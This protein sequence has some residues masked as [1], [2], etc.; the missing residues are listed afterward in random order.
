MKRIRKKHMAPVLFIVSSFA[1][2]ILIGTLLLWCP[3]STTSGNH[4]NFIDAFFTSTSAVC[5]TGLSPVKDLSLTLTVFGKIVLAFLIQ[6]GGLGMV[7]IGVFILTIVGAKIGIGNRYLVK[8]ALNQNTANG[9]VKLVK[10]IVLITFIIE[11]VGFLLN[12]IVFAQDF[13]LGTAIGIS[14]FHAISSFNNAGFDIIGSSSLVPYTNNVLLNLSTAGMI[15]L[16]GLG[17]IV[18]REII[19]KRSLRK[20]SIHSKIVLKVTLSLI[21]IGTLLIKLLEGDN[22]TWLQAFFQ[23]VTARTAGFATVD[24]SLLSNATTVLFFFLMF[25]GAAPCSTG[26]GIKVSAFYTIYKSIT[27]FARGKKCLVSGR[28]IEEETK[29]KAFVVVVFGICALM[30]GTFIILAIEEAVGNKDASLRNIL[31]EVISSFGTVGLSMGIT[32]ELS[33]LSKVVLCVIMFLGR[34]GPISILNLWNHNWNRPSSSSVTYL[35]EKL[36][37][38]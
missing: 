17:F 38:G 30:I 14:I 7:T 3:F 22:V 31:F 2:A 33:P 23:S 27:S 6:I 15:I 37:I 12:L 24:F 36:I 21:I 32:S 4:F 13:E 19:A 5:V 1:I 20:L 16:G 9:L 11:F 10:H 18:I 35:K 34:I 25:I 28:E 29:L 26:G 8:E